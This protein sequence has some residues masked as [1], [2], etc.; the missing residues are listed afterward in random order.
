MYFCTQKLKKIKE[1]RNLTWAIA[2]VAM[3]C[4]CSGK[5]TKKQGTDAASDAALVE[6]TVKYATGFSVLLAL[7]RTPRNRALMRLLMLPSWK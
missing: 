4:S 5:N 7:V 3:L 1:M 6:V 2:V